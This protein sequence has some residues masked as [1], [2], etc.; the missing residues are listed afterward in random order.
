MWRHMTNRADRELSQQL[1]ATAGAISKIMPADI[2]A[3]AERLIRQ[4]QEELDRGESPDMERIDAK[5]QLAGPLRGP[6][7]G[8]RARP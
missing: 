5:E 1:R 4:D 3:E 7:A 6:A 8:R 2:T